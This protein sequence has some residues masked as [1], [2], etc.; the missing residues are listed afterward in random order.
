MSVIEGKAIR[1]DGYEEA[2]VVVVG[3][4]MGGASLAA[5]IAEAGKRVVIVE[6]GGYY[7]GLVDPL[8]PNRPGRGELDQREDD[9]LVRIDGGRGFD[10]H[11]RL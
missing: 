10:F 11:R 4:G 7:T 6:R 5:R 1:K 2:D 3:S 9:M 8:D